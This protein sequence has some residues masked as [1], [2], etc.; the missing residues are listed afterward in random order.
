MNT[1]NVVL[2]GKIVQA[3]EGESILEVAS[4]NG[5]HI[6]T[7]CHDPR[8]EPFSSCYVCV[9]E[10]EKMRGLQPSCSTK[11]TEGMVVNTETEEIKQSRKMALD[12]LVSNHY[13]DCIGPCKDTCPAGVDVQGYISLIEKGM[14]SEAIGLIKEANPLPAICGRVCVR[15]CEAACRRN[16]IDEGTGVGIDYLKRYAADKDLE[17]DNH[18]SP[19]LAPATGKKVAVI[20]GGPGGLSAAYWLAQKGHEVEIFEGMPN[21]GGWLRYG[22]PEYRLPNELIDKEISTITELGVKLTTN[23]KLGDNLSYK[24]I[25]E[26]FDATIL[27]IGSQRG[28][29]VGVEGEDADGVYSGI[30][31][32]R[33]MEATGQKYDFKGKTVIVVGGGNTAMDCCRTSKRCGAD[34]VIVVYRRTEA[35]MPANPIEIHE[36]KLEGIEYMLLTNP[37]A[38]NKDEESKLKS[39]VCVKMELGEPDA[40]GRRR[41][42]PI[43][44]SEFELEVDILLAAI[45]QKTDV[46]F[47]DDIN[48]NTDNGE[49]KINRWGNIDA[50]SDTLETG[51]PGVFA[52][53]DS[54]TGPATAI[55]AIAQAKVAVHSCDQHLRSEEI[56]P[57]PKEFF[58]KKDNFKKQ[59]PTDYSNKFKKQMREEM[60]VLDADKRMNFD[61]VELGYANED[62]AKHET[63]RCL[64]CGCQA[65]YTCDLKEYATEYGAVQ[66][67][68]KGSFNEY[69]VDFSHPYLEFDPSKCILCGRC[70]RICNEVVGAGALGFINRGF[71]T[72][73]APAMGDSLTHTDCESCGL[74]LSTCPTGAISENK[75]FKPGPVKTETFNTICTYCSVGCEIEVQHRN[76]FVMGVKGANG[77]INTDGNL[78]AKGRFGYQYMND[79]SRIL[80]PQLKENGQWKEIEWSEAIDLIKSKIQSVNP[81]ENAFMAGARLSNEEMYLIQKLAR[82]GVKTNNVASFHYMERGKGYSMNAQDT[83]PFS[84]IKEASDIYILGGNLPKTNSVAGFFIQNARATKNIPVTL[85]KS[86]NC[87]TMNRKVDRI[88]DVKSQYALFKAMNYYLLANGKQNSMFINGRTTGYEDYYQ[89]IQKEN[90]DALIEA[91]GLSKDTVEKLANEINNANNAILAYTEDDISSAGALEILNFSLITGKQG[92]TASGTVV[93]KTKNNSQ[94]LR[95][96][97]ICPKT[98]IGGRS[99][100]ESLEDMKKLWGVNDLSDRVNYSIREKLEKHKIKNLFIFGEDPAGTAMDKKAV[101]ELVF[102]TDFIVVADSFMSETA[103]AANL[104]LPLAF[105]LETGGSFTNTQ[106]VIQRFEAVRKAKTGVNNIE[107]MNKLHEAFELK[108]YG[109]ADE[110]FEELSTLLPANAENMFEFSIT[111]GD[112][113]RNLFVTGADYLANRFRKEFMSAFKN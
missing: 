26:K 103:K 110:V 72:Y 14:Y 52:A 78:C 17:S 50:K 41:P 3:T 101:N 71:D 10:V 19:E 67:K 6:P 61:E 12:L 107:L 89:A 24:E 22:I 21:P 86:C 29:L 37:V 66:D 80:K 112:N 109:N 11:V 7:L 81:D 31:F 93:L 32:L 54:V 96:M 40:S 46:N 83:V 82:A 88:M 62:V 15:P 47:I 113:P 25:K 23:K 1:L 48:A 57:L 45:G 35:E 105:Q 70:V 90:Y 55:E 63:G 108:T 53:G 39:I 104:V 84:Q 34:K 2:N 9:V 94:G 74:C 43:E 42:I 16:L 79:N 69:N 100:T 30:D 99:L 33:N 5:Y 49:L 65:L 111:D 38:I 97:G 44:G 85:L 58:S 60:P 56:K 102:N 64:E 87:D 68:F 92:K 13:A 18:F 4:R 27:T 98:A 91:S 77:I 73:V 36:S 76:G 28:T 95:D 106:K 8:L 51:I 20:G 75:L 59:D